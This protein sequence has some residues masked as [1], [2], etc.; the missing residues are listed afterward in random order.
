[1]IAICHGK[2]EWRFFPYAWNGGGF[3]MPRQIGMEAFSILPRQ[4]GVNFVSICHG[5]LEWI[6]FPYATSS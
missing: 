3:R 4:I 2:L 6:L 1:M 5:K